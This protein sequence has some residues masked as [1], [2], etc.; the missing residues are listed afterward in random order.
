MFRHPM[1]SLILALALAASALSAG[2]GE[3]AFKLYPGATQYTPPDTEETRQFTSALRPDTKITAYLSNDSFE[4]V[5]AFYR[6]LGKEYSGRKAPVVDKLPNGNRIRK[7]FVIL[8][9]APDLLSSREWIRIQRPFVGSAT[10][11]E[12]KPVSREVRD[13]T[14]IVLT[15][16]EEVEKKKDT[17]RT[18]DESQKK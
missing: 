14:E 9:G 6:G 5:V 17:S 12:G 8:D 18:Q 10:R 11:E 2:G 13:V 16:K 1:R 15:E 4:K 3:K 7:T